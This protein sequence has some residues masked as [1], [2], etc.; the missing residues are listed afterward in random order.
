MFQL[1]L[2]D[3]L[4][5]SIACD[6]RQSGDDIMADA[7]EWTQEHPHE[8]AEIQSQ[9][10]SVVASRRK[11]SLRVIVD[12]VCWQTG[13]GCKHALTAAFSRLLAKRIPNYADSFQM[14]KSKTDGVNHG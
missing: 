10:R 7:I 8:W 12:G 5:A 1:S 13:T 4:A 9:V 3:R 2:D 11:A 6:Y 14:N